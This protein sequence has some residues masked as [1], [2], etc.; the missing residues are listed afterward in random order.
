MRTLYRPLLTKFQPNS[1]KILTNLI[2]KFNPQFS[3]KSLL[4]STHDH[5]AE[6]TQGTSKGPLQVFLSATTGHQRHRGTPHKYFIFSPMNYAYSITRPHNMMLMSIWRSIALQ[7]DGY[8][9]HLAGEMWYTAG[10]LCFSTV[11]LM[12]ITVLLENRLRQWVTVSGSG[13]SG[14]LLGTR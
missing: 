7:G 11:G 6:N 8:E 4:C 14:E 9:I 13:V 1:M 12:G 3:I 2:N 10:C 5:T